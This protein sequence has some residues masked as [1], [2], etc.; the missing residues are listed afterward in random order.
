VFST[1]PRPLYRRIVL[2]AGWASGLSGCKKN[3]ACMGLDPGHSSPQQIAF[4]NGTSIKCVVI[5]LGSLLLGGGIVYSVQ[6]LLF[7]V[8]ASEDMI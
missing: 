3:L 5:K 1:K 2:E 6:R 8:D 7:E 4:R